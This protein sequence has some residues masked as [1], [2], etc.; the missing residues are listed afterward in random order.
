VPG[1]PV[2]RGDADHADVVTAQPGLVEVV[3]EEPGE[4]AKMTAP[5]ANAAEEA[6]GDAPAADAA[7]E[8]PDTS[9]PEGAGLA[10]AL[11]P[12]SS[13]QRFARLDALLAA[14]D[15]VRRRDAE[16]SSAVVWAAVLLPI[17]EAMEHADIDRMCWFEQA[18]DR[19]TERVRFTRRDKDTLWLLL[20]GLEQL[21]PRGRRG[22]AARHMVT[23]PWFKETLLLFTLSKYAAGESLDD[24]GRW[25]AIAQH[26]QQSYRQ[27]RAGERAPRPQGRG[28]RDMKR[29][30]RSRRGGGG[31]GG[32]RRGGRRRG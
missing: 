2:P 16:V 10:V 22:N 7:V 29:G 23:R 11:L 14:I 18:L 20:R 31:G 25:K 1:V 12:P 24:V 5:E 19:W 30:R 4:A 26:H 6:A 27:P 3:Q 13:E 8:L 21:E 15:E 9:L 17:W 28:D 32:G